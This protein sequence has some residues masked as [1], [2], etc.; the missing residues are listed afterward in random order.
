MDRALDD[1]TV[2]DISTTPAG[3]WCSRLLADF[4]ADVMVAEPKGG[5]LLRKLAPFGRDGKS[6]PAEFWLANKRSRIVDR[7]TAEGRAELLDLAQRAHVLVASSEVAELQQLGL[8]YEEIG[9]ARLVMVHV[10]PYGV[11]GPLA[12]EPAN[13]LTVAARS[14]WASI[15]GLASREP[16]KPSGWQASYCGGVA[17][18]I[19]VLAAL[20]EREITGLGQEIDVSMLDAMLAAFAP[21]FLR[22]QYTD[23][24]MRRK[25][26]ADLL[27]GPVPVK[28]GHF[29][30]TLSRAQ[31]WRDAMNLLALPDLAEDPRWETSWYRQ[32]HK[33]EYVERVTAAMSTWRKADLFD[34]LAA[35]RVVAGPVLTMEELS[36]NEHLVARGFWPETAG[37]RVF[38]GAPVRLS[39]T[40]W[41]LGKGAPEPG[42]GGDERRWPTLLGRAPEPRAQRTGPLEG[43]Q[44]IVLTQAW[45]GTFCTELL[46]L[47]GADIVQVEVRKRFDSWRGEASRPMGEKIEAISTAQHPWNTHFL[48]NS[49]NL[50]KRCVTLDLQDERGRETFLALVK[51]ADVMAENFSPRVMGNL[52]I[53]YDVL[54]EINPGMIVCS[55]SAYGHDGPW[56]NVPGIGGTIEPSSGMSALLGYEDGPPMNSGQ[57]YP[58]AVAG[59][60]GAAGILAAL[61]HRDRTGSGQYLDLSMME[62]NLAHTGDAALEYLR[63]GTQRPRMGNRHTTFAP[64]GIYRCNGDERWIAIACETERQWQALDGNDRRRVGERRPLVDGGRPQGTRR[65]PGRGDRGVD[66]FAGTRRACGETFGCGRGC[67]AGARWDRDRPGRDCPAARD[68][69]GD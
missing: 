61:R 28:D 6:I 29:A 62:A 18:F 5:S 11:V 30:L 45:A 47:L 21:A 69:G 43:V 35:R 53:G 58:D 2:L 32:Q 24:P 25:D 48:Y 3:A 67:G 4:G 38:P 1:L 50:N 65:R 60:Y 42:E 8:L 34:E 46:A 17:S 10:T 36:T 7:E 56:A 33:E 54:H 20:H 39:E 22:A 66:G 57:M 26:G 41:D 44:G 19:A 23:E 63:N 37:G 14:G 16:L 64:H 52:G 15:N 27:A 31:F 59:Y 9:S 13:D 12:G 51:H 68:P 55:L 49:V 40:P